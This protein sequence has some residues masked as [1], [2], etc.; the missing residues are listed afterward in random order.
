MRPLRSI[1]LSVLASALLIGT[2]VAQ[3][4]TPA[5]RIV[6][7]IDE[8]QLVTLKGN[9]HPAANAK[10]DRG[11]VSPTL[12]MTDLIMVLSRS[13]EQQAAFDKFVAG[14][15]DPNSP[16]YHHWLEPEEVGTNF[17]PSQTDIATISNWLTGHGFTIDEV[18]KDRMAIRFSGTAG[19]VESAFH[20]EIHN[21]DVKGEAH[22]GNMSD[23]QIPAALA[24]AVVGVKSL[25]NFFAK[26]M[27]KL[28]SKVTRSSETGK[29]ERPATAPSISSGTSTA[30]KSLSIRPEFGINTG[31]GSSANLIEDVTPYDFATIYNVL[32][33]WNAASPI[34]GT[35]QTIAIAATSSINLAD[36]T[37]FRTAF[38]LPTTNAA[39]TPQRVSGNSSPVTVCTDTTGT[40][41]F[42][43][44][45]CGLGDLV[46]NSL[47]VEWS[48][49]VAKNAQIVIV[50]SYPTSATDD[51]L[52]DSENYIIN[53]K[54][55]KIMNVSYGLCELGLGTAGNTSYNNLWQTAYTEGIAVFVASGDEGSASCDAGEDS[56]FG[57]PWSAQFGASVSGFASTPYNTAVGGTDF[58]WCNENSTTACPAAPYWSTTNNATGASALGYLPEVP[59]NDTCS[60]P[61]VLSVLQSIASQIGNDP[62]LPFKGTV[63]DSET[64]CNY[65]ANN[66]VY[67]FQAYTYSGSNQPVDIS[68]FVD[69]TGGSGG[70]SSCTSSNGQTVASCTG[71]YA[72]PSWQTGVTGVPSDN[73]RDIPDV[74]FFASNGFLNSAYLICVSEA[75]S[76]CTYSSTVENGA[77]EIGGTSASSPAMAGVMALINQKAGS[78]QGNPNAELYKLASQQTYGSCSAERG[79]GSPVT[80]SACLFNDIDTG[81]IA[82]PCD[83]GA[84]DGGILYN[85]AGIPFLVAQQ[86]G[87][88]SPNCTPLDSGDTV[89]LHSGFSATAG[90]DL[91][92]GLGSLN[93]A[94]VVNAWPSSVSPSFGVSGIGVT[95]TGGA[96][97]GNTSTILVTPLDGFTGTVSLSCSVTTAPSGATSPVTC[98]SITPSAVTI[99]G[100][101]G[102][103]ATLTVGSTTTTTGGAYAITVTGTSG[104]ITETA[105]INVTLNGVT[106]ANGTF[107]LAPPTASPATI[108][109]G[110][111]ATSTVT[112]N[113]TANSLYTGTVS[114]TCSVAGPSGA[115]DLP[116]CS[117]TSTNSTVALNAT[118]M[119]G[120]VTYSVSTTAATSELVRPKIGNGRGWAGAGSGAVLAL[121]LFFGIPARRRSWQ[122]M[123]GVLVLMV[124]LGSLA[125]CGGGGSG[126]GG[127]SQSNPGT[128]AGVYRMTV[129][130]VGSPAPSTAP[131]PVTFTVTVN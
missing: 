32:P 8:H 1:P 3:Q 99:S 9:T 125:G 102:A 63:R 47:D 37:A 88:L 43:S 39:N 110:G 85:A 11:P 62:N 56:N 130:P 14:Q 100:T 26:P 55:A 93:V 131:T 76:A 46:E 58:N 36:I 59:W 20:T 25:H 82:M 5:I 114:F 104:S 74:S 75:G 103:T 41:P 48:G 17:G 77:Q 108:A 126:G 106:V 65:V 53:N 73:K 107:T 4:F 124:A 91:A 83:Y 96:T 33:L 54:T 113:T 72:K 24:P 13:P 52:W 51:G 84:A 78:P 71:G 92:T 118:S 115:T 121:L 109:P 98:G 105:I 69:T 87:F 116:S 81:T 117:L 2:A 61:L 60:N 50:S 34:D 40:L 95:I 35:G 28:G 18:T 64:A 27:H 7:Q 94:N 42:Q 22:I 128:T 67:I 120:T 21:L 123:L 31:S 29:W 15:Y 129:T 23:P 57:T 101:S 89:A 45:P 122:S 79:N 19:Q 66:S 38:S 70:A 6:N 127:G 44:N 30:T 86:Q 119:S 90:F 97:T 49:A 112:V 16:D 12:P 10:N 111:T 80:S 68:Y